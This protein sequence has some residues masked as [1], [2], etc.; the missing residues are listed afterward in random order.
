[1]LSG[2]WFVLANFTRVTT[3]TT[4]IPCLLQQHSHLLL[5]HPHPRLPSSGA[6]LPLSRPKHRPNN[7]KQQH[8]H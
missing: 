6:L 4:P 2:V 3:T 8:Q 1:V 5:P 7:N